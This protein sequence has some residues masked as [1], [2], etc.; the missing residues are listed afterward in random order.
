MTKYVK[1]VGQHLRHSISPALQQAAFDK[2]G[3]DVQYGLLE[4][5]P[6]QVGAA[7]QQLRQPE[8]LGANVTVPYK[9]TVMPFLD[10]MDEQSAKVG[11]VNTIVNQSGRLIGHNTD[12]DGFLQALIREGGFAPENKRVVLLGAGGVAR[13]A[14]FIL[15]KA[16]VSSLTI[17]GRNRE[18]A[19]E[20]RSLL[21]ISGMRV[22]AVTFDDRK[23]QNILA[24]CDLLVNC[25]SVGMKYSITEG[26]SP[27]NANLISNKIFVY[28]VVYNPQET[29]L[30]Q[31]AR[32]V[33][34]KTLG[35]LPMLV[36]QGAA[37]FELWTGE[38]APIDVML[39]VARQAL[40]G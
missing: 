28:D 35:G 38:K 13:A 31:D 8:Y 14:G 24:S 9:Q 16:G 30:L 36:Y 20:L 32:K 11:A 29:C 15:I 25:T 33:G 22:T 23:L 34:A 5:E 12:A 3:L 40:E 39:Q 26:Q 27:L 2:Y 37:A 1:L 4:L 10:E 19:E 17:I 7:L 18:H 6:G 21:G